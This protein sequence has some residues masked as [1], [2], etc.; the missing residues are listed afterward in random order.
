MVPVSKHQG[1]SERGMKAHE[2]LKEKGRVFILSRLR[3][4]ASYQL[5][6]LKLCLCARDISASLIHI[7]EPVPTRGHLKR[8]IPDRVRPARTQALQRADRLSQQEGEL[9]Y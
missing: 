8:I 2:R 1:L 7:S 5:Y 6:L 9:G 4:R 3:S